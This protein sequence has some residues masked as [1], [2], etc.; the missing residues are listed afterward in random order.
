[1]HADR[2]KEL[3]LAEMTCWAA[4]ERLAETLCNP[5]E[6]EN[7]MGR[8][9]KVKADKSLESV[10]IQ[11]LQKES[12]YSILSEESGFHKGEGNEYWIVDPLDG[13]ANFS[14]GL[15]IYC[16]SVG[17]WR[18]N[19]PILGAVLDPHNKQ[20][21]SGIVGDG[22]KCNGCEIQVRKT[23][24]VDPLS[25]VLCTGFPAGLEHTNKDLD[26]I[27]SL[28][29]RFGK[30]RMLGSAALM[31]CYVASGRC[32]SYWERQIRLWDVAAGL[33]IVVS[34]GGQ[35]KLGEIS[36]DFKV[37]VEAAGA[38]SLLASQIDAK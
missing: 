38:T 13:S 20:L 7:S 29:S 33:A 9:W 2:H 37:D 35:F 34:A 12:N 32:D 10:I 11:N 36:D 31:L 24:D 27:V 25:S 4:K 15:P 6:L 28:I 18:D 3:R 16:I 14:R 17:L 1:M 19:L 30:V 23:L 8:E 26:N 21:F 22:A 5:R